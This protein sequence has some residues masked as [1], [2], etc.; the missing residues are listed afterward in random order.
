VRAPGQFAGFENYPNIDKEQQKNIDD[1]LQ[2]AN[3]KDSSKQQAY[4]K[5]L[6]YAKTAAT[7]SIVHPVAEYT[8]AT[9]WRTKHS[10]GPGSGF[11]VLGD[12]GG[13]TFYAPESQSPAD[14]A[15]ALA[16]QARA[17][18]ANR[19]TDL[20]RHHKAILEIGKP[21]LGG[22]AP[23][24]LGGHAYAQPSVAPSSGSAL[25]HAAAPGVTGNGAIHTVPSAT[26]AAAALAPP[27]E[28]PY[29]MKSPEAFVQAVDDYF[30]QR[31]HQPLSTTMAF[32]ARL[33]PLYPGMK[34]PG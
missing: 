28:T 34:I 8:N 33:S 24:A 31:T 1:D 9:A 32:N 14:R 13:N 15:R 30:F 23:R 7:E 29:Y 6:Q 21:S 19:R 25:P 11:H 22:F 4:Q 20:E 2:D 27:D 12:I 17:D 16:A 18:A 10:K 3:G 26:N 5:F